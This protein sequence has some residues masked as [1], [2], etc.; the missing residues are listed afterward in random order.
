V[1]ARSTLSRTEARALYDRIGRGQDTQAV[2][3]D[4]AFDVLIGHGN[5][6]AARA[7][8]E[9]GC[10]TGRLAERL[11]RDHCPPTTRYVG[12]DLSPRMVEI[13]RER[14]A[15]VG[16]RATVVETD[17]SFAFALADESQD[18]VVATYLL[19]LLSESDI[20]VFLDEAHRLLDENGGLCLAGLTWGDDGLSRAVSGAWA[21]LHT[22]RPTWM[23]G[24]RPLRMRR[25]LDDGP[26]AIAHHEVVRAWGVPSEVLVATPA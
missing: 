10:G 9:V 20:Q 14:L 11:L 16:D 4:P 24:C 25:F 6:G 21:A 8:L 2:Y 15:S 1:T 22:L 19:D 18:R 12:A 17:G 13:A 7:V 5:F 3:E 23:G 26:W